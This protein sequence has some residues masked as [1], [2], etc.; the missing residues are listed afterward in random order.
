MRLNARSVFFW[1][2]EQADSMERMIRAALSINSVSSFR[3]A[4][5]RGVPAGTMRNRKLLPIIKTNGAPA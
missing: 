5:A 2:G 1:R 3:G 4:V